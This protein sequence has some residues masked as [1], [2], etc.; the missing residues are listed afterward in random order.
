[1]IRNTIKLLCL[2]FSVGLA[3]TA[4]SSDD[5]SPVKPPIVDPEKPDPNKV[6]TFDFSTMSVAKQNSFV[7]N[8]T[9][10]LGTT[11]SKEWQPT[12]DYLKPMSLT[13][14]KEKLTVTYS[15]DRK[16][17]YMIK[18]NNNDI[19]IESKNHPSYTFATLSTDKKG[20]VINSSFFRIKGAH[21][22]LNVNNSASLQE[23]GIVDFTSFKNKYNHL[24]NTSGKYL[25]IAFEYKLKN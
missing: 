18:I 12:I 16:Q 3:T 22:T 14:D 5:S 15:E 10:E 6:M 2:C 11:I 8:A 21:K 24:K 23:Y 13:L 1:M 7:D 25:Q 4:C 17:E 20:L 19:I 9:T